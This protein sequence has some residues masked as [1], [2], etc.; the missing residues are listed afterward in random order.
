LGSYRYVLGSWKKINYFNYQLVGR[1]KETA[2]NKERFSFLGE[3]GKKRG[4]E[5]KNESSRSG[6]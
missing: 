6:S 3:K 2:K 5:K 4:K 1:I